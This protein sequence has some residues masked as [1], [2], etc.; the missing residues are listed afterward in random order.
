MN[1]IEEKIWAYIDGTCSLEEQ[2]I[3]SNLIKSDPIYKDKYKEL[4]IF[5]TD[6]LALD[7]DEP[8]M[9]F[10]NK[11]MEKISL[12]S[13]PL[14]ARA[15]IDKRIIYTIS[16]V[17]GMMLLAC[18]VFILKEVNWSSTSDWSGG[19]TINFNTL[20]HKAKIPIVVRNVS[21]YAFF[22]FDTVAG[23]MILDKFLR[24]KLS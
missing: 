6:M 11:V 10:T 3:I 14:S 13:K 9:A 8:S 4:V 12:Q 19:L 15:R 2:E 5:H 16:A 21:L 7:M 1:E 17:F 22:L 24:R 18:L 23:L 20:N